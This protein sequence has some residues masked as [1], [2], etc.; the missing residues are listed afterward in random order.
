MD[1][2][3]IDLMGMRVFISIIGLVG[4]VFLIVSII[5]TRLTAVK[6]FELFLLGLA[7][8]NVE[9]IIIVNVYDIMILRTSYTSTNTWLCRW[10]KFLTAWGEISSILFTVLISIFRYQKLR[11]AKKRVSLPIYMD[12]IR[13][14]WMVSGVCVMVSIT[15]GIPIF[16]INLQDSSVNLTVNH[17]GCPPD[18]FPCSKE[19]CPVLNRAYKYLFL[20][21]CNMLPLIIVTVTSCL[22]VMVLLSQRSTVTP[23]TSV[24][25]HFGRKNKR[26]RL[27]RSTLAVMAAMALF[28]VDWT[29]YLIFQLSFNPTEYPFWADVEFFIS[30]SY[31]SISPY[32]YG[33]GN[34]LFSVNNFMK[35]C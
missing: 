35:K 18:F 9:E 16:V 25:S 30:T 6:S 23:V 29:L 11:D 14:A 4:N 26:P 1:H 7:T 34:N 10:L 13:V 2:F 33:I 21:L 17:T 8:A 24:C 28:Q 32:V 20:M 19:H 12:S 3:N 31:T 27:Q 22:I 15:L 5:H